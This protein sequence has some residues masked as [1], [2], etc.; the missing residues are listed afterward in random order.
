MVTVHVLLEIKDLRRLGVLQ[1][2]YTRRRDA[3]KRDV[4]LNLLRAGEAGDG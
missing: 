1:E 2:G 4:M 3:H